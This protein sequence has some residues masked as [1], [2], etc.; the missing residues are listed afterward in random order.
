MDLDSGFPYD[1]IEKDRIETIVSDH[2]LNF[3]YRINS[4]HTIDVIGDVVFPDFASFLTELPLRFNYVSGNFDCSRLVNLSSL[5]GSPVHVHGTFNCA[6]TKITSLEY[7]P[8]SAGVLVFDNNISSLA[9]GNRNC[10]FNHVHMLMINSNPQNSLSREIINNKE[11]FPLILKYQN[12]FD[13]WDDNGA[14]N[15][16]GFDMLIAEIKEGLK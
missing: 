5:K 9:T 16:R 10:K 15:A 1:F 13:V 6:F 12:Y 11:Y 7:V 2:W 14:F 4:D 8:E 3:D